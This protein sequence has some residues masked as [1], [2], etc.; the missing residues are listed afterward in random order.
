MEQNRKG[1]VGRIGGK[2]VRK[3]MAV[4]ILALLLGCLPAAGCGK[5][6]AWKPSASTENLTGKYLSK[7]RD[8]S[9]VPVTDS[10]RQSYAD[11][12]LRLLCESR[13]QAKEAGS[14]LLMSPLSVITALEMARSGARGETEGQMAR[15]LYGG[16]L[17]KETREELMAYLQ[18]LPSQKDASFHYANS[19]WFSG[20]YE[21]FTV[22]ED[23]LKNS[24]QDYGAEIYRAPFD[25]GT[26]RDINGWV[27]QA[28]DGMIQDIL[29]QVPERA[30][31]Y[32]MNGMAFDAKWKEQYKEDQIHPAE[33]YPQEG[34]LQTVDMMYSQESGLIRGESVK[35]FVK[36][37]QEGYAFA[38]FLPEDGTTVDQYL[39]GLSGEEFLRLLERAQEEQEQVVAGLPRYS[40]RTNF[41]LNQVLKAMGM[42][43][44]FNVEQADFGG[45]G[46]VQGEN[47]YIGTVIHSTLIEVD[48]DGTRAGAATVVAMESGGV[49][50]EPERVILDRPFLYAIVD[51]K[52]N[53]PVFIGIMDTVE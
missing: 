23:F 41:T 15:T 49:A 44:A 1:A 22:D 33:F 18:T 31:M 21:G 38:A 40:A 27:E 25:Q 4:G 20:G 52:E 5:Q 36:P 50:T 37:Y 46:R 24:A 45:M 14:N 6:P 32:L 16:E 7:A 17:P 8:Y 35:G 34:G 10:F 19:I 51:T 48:A 43:L 28:T 47:I 53:L 12:S 2:R 13:S 11:F 26:L 39:A 30:V 42:P 3:R 29:D 9:E